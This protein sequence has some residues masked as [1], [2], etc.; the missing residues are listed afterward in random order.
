MPTQQEFDALPAKDRYELATAARQWP[1]Q[2]LTT[3]GVLA[4]LLF[5]GGGL[6]YTART[7]ETGQDTLKATQ[8]QQ[9]TDRYTKAVEQLGSAQ[10]DVRL[11]GIYALQRLATDSPRD[12]D[13]I[14]EVLA[15][16][17]RGHD[18][19]TPLPKSADL[20]KQCTSTDI[21][22]AATLP[23]VRP[24]ADVRAAMTLAADLSHDTIPGVI[25]LGPSSPSADLTRVRFPLADLTGVNLRNTDLSD[26]NLNG[27]NLGGANL[28]GA[29]LRGANLS[30][31]DLR[32]ADLRGANLQGIVGAT[33]QQIRSQA[34]VD[35]T[36]K[37]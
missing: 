23:L 35:E 3:A 17:V 28:H 18:L 5:T 27:A 11:G 26:A 34:I 13:T 20:P 22:E 16:F 30:T 21:M 10:A 33:E 14:R 19:C 6:I 31:A 37:F 7:W 25:V 1:W 24:M 4:G 12:R 9:I 15:S 36:T 32:G 2:H 29:D 8:Q